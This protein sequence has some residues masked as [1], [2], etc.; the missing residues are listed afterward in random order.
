MVISPFNCSDII[1]TIS[2][3]QYDSLKKIAVVCSTI[4][5]GIMYAEQEVFRVRRHWNRTV[6]II[7]RS[8][9]EY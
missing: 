7:N 3:K 1:F 5:Q 6:L 8:S 9:V 4:N 2:V